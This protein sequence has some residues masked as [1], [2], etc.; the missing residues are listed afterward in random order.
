MSVTAC[1]LLSLNKGALAT[2]RKGKRYLL[3]FRKQKAD[4][5][6]LQETHSKIDSEKCWRNEWGG[7]IIM[8]HKSSNSHGVANLVKKDVDCT[9]HSKILDSSGQFVIIKTEIKD[10]MYVLINIYAFSTIC[11]RHCKKI[12][13]MKKTT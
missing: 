11:Q 5:I 9:I 12:T 1:K 2:L 13:L 3:G 8:A 6:L 4:F 7:K 10:K